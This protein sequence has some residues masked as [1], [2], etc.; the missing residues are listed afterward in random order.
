MK[1]VL[2]DVYET[3]LTGTR[4]QDREPGLRQV[5]SHFGLDYP[6]SESLCDRLDREIRIENQ[7]SQE[8][9]PEVDIRE[10]WKRIFPSLDRP[11]AFSLAAEEAIHPVRLKAG[12]RDLVVDFHKQ[13]RLLGIVSNA[14]AYTRILLEKHLGE[15]WSHFTP[16]LMIFS[17]EHRT[18]KPGR[19]IFQIALDRLKT[20]GIGPHETLMVGDSIVNDIEPAQRLG[21]QARLVAR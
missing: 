12:A 6:S 9:H 18:S 5:L 2:F 10:I 21:M 14:Q 7:Q 20:H 1:A 16:D 8:P 3:L 15:A 17:Y 11:D 19:A 13:G 4:L